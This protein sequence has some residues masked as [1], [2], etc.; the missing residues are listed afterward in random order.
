MSRAESLGKRKTDPFQTKLR[1]LPKIPKIREKRLRR[2]EKKAIAALK[3]Q[4][5]AHIPR[6]EKKDA[7]AS[8][9]LRT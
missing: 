8:K 6:E 3:S 2:D 5:E 7:F 9:G 1:S 4:K